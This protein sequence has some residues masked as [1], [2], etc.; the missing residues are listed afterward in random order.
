M[1]HWRSGVMN[2]KNNGWNGN[3]Q[4]TPSQQNGFL[5]RFFQKKFFSLQPYRSNDT[6]KPTKEQL[7][8]IDI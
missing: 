7:K 3:K 4:K 2:Q 6:S 8:D 5:I 1:V